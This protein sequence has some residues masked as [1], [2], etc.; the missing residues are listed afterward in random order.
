MLDIHAHRGWRKLNIDA[1]GVDTRPTQI[2]S[3]V[4]ARTESQRP[5][6]NNS[7][8]NAVRAGRQTEKGSTSTPVGRAAW[9]TE[10]PWLTEVLTPGARTESQRPV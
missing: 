1:R 3:R 10:T 8:F 5:L 6:E 9:L 7:T 4:G 2:S